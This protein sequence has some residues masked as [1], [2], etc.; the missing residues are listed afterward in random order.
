VSDDEYEKLLSS[1]TVFAMPSLYEG[2]GL[3]VLDAM[4]RGIP[5]LTS[6]AGSLAEVAGDAAFVVDPESVSSIS[7]GLVKLLTRQQ[8]RE[9]LKHE[10]PKRAAQYSWKRTV[11]LFLEALDNGK[12]KIE[13]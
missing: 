13:N 11:D 2:F 7:D 12:L 1:C 6:H 3:Q 9:T 4:Q 10:G 8:L 5:V